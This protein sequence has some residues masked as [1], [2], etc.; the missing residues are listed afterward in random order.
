MSQLL[1]EYHAGATLRQISQRHGVP[2]GT[3]YRYL[4]EDCG[5]T[6]AAAI[7]KRNRETA[8]QEIARS[9]GKAVAAA[10]E[11]P[12]RALWSR[13]RHK[14]VL[15]ARQAAF[16]IARQRGISLSSIGRAFGR[17]HTTVMHGIRKIKRLIAADK[18][19]AAFVAGI[20]AEVAEV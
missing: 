11:I 9:I 14:G 15:E 13:A 10:F 8:R 4:T 17:D 19:F 18:D 5:G 6:D 3:L 20:S 7:S 2:S 1:A 16:L 12:E